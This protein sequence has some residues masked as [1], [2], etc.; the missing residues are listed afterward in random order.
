MSMR[1][2]RSPQMAVWCLLLGL[3][4]S[5]VLA[6]GPTSG[7]INGSVVDNTGAVL[8]GVT[9]TCESPA[10][11]GVQMGVTN[12]TGDYRFPSIPPGTY[13]VT[14]S[15]PGFATVVRDGVIIQIG[16]TATINVKMTIAALEET[17]TVSGESPIVDVQNTGVK[18]AFN[19]EMLKNIPNA[20]DIWSL[21]AEAPGMTV[22]RFDVGGST[23]GTQTGYTSYGAGGQN[24]VQ[25]DGANTTEGTSAAGFYFDYGAFDEVSFG[26]SSAADASMPTPGVLVNTVLKSGGNQFHGDVYFDYENEGLQGDNAS[27]DERLVK[28]GLGQGTRT[29]KYLDPNGNLGGP[30]KRDKLWFFTSWRWQEI[31]VTTAGWPF[32]APGTGPDF[33]T[34]LRNA[35]YKLTYQLSPNN[36]VTHFLQYGHKLQPYR[37]AGAS[38]SLDGVYNQDSGSW[39]GKVEHSWIASPTLYFDFRAGSFG[40]NWPNNPYT[41][42]LTLGTGSELAY[43]RTDQLTGNTAGGY[44]GYRY[45]RRR[46]QGEVV[47][48][49]YRDDWLGSDHSFKFGWLSEREAISNEQMPS[50]DNLSLTFRSSSGV[51]FTTPYRVTLTNNPTRSIDALWHHGAFLQDQFNLGEKV[52]VNAGVR[53]DHYAAFQPEQPVREA[54]FRDFFYAG[55]PLQTSAGPYSLERASFADTWVVPASGSIIKYSNLI[56]PRFGL[57]WDLRGDGKTVLKVS[58]GRFYENPG[59]ATDDVNPIQETSATFDWIDRNGD[60]LFT[61]DELGRFRSLSGGVNSSLSPDLKDPWTDEASVFFERQVATDMGVRVGFVYKKQ[62]NGLELIDVGRPASLWSVPFTVND[63]GPDGLT[64]TPDDGPGFTAY[65]LST[66]TV[67]RSELQSRDDEDETYKNIDITFNKRMSHRWSLLASFLYTWRQ[68]LWFGSPQNP[69]EAMNNVADSTMWTAKVF[70]TWEAPYGFLVSPVLR[71]QAGDAL[72]RRLSVGTNGGTI[73]MVVEPQGSYR[74][75][76]VTLFDLRTEKEFRLGGGRRLGLFFDMYNINNTNAAQT[77]DSIVGR[78]TVVQP[79]GSSL[80]LPRFLRP[81]VIIAPRIIKFGLKFAF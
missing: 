28:Y 81:T 6:Q 39:A 8:P 36:K 52:T 77:M 66:V 51:D 32:E 69:N 20:R 45:D 72:P 62:N 44:P 58:A 19:A 34:R 79:D 59:T 10:L 65:N 33:L 37:N 57:S 22:S 80:N 48:G 24:R 53:W 21:M 46:W 67:S 2:T 73:T 74:E 7:S 56:A 54:P 9:V 31:R 30:I 70:G 71:H 55:V 4:S 38:V 49:L 43:R 3:V 23:A 12:A 63:P 16:F 29:T 64:G 15:L 18:N 5:P 11:L 60:R 75:D 17:I 47:G 35:T 27:Q 1:P 78:R 14:Y 13:T 26:I 76:N 40:Y 42:D 50:R 61:M 41:P 68:E 25:I